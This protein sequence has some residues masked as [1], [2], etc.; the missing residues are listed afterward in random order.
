MSRRYIP[1]L[2]TLLSIPR[3]LITHNETNQGLVIREAI[4]LTCLLLIALTHR[5]F[6]IP[7][8]EAPHYYLL[9]TSLLRDNKVNWFPFLDLKLWALVVAG[10]VSEGAKREWYVGEIKGVMGE[11]GLGK[12]CEM[13][14]VVRGVVWVEVPLEEG[15]RGLVEDLQAAIGV[16][17]GA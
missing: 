15:V 11:L 12:T 17:G 5:K 3:H 7:P 8:D 4:R 9:V 6:S 1:V 2:H 10:G 13:M 16:E 14:E